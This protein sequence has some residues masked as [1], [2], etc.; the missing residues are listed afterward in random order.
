L[1][2]VKQQR[3]Y[4]TPF[5]LSSTFF[6]L[7][8]F[9]QISL[10]FFGA[11]A[12]FF[13][14]FPSCFTLLSNSNPSPWVSTSS[15]QIVARLFVSVLQPLTPTWW[16][17]PAPPPSGC[18]RVKHTPHPHSL[19]IPLQPLRTDVRQAAPYT[20]FSPLNSTQLRRVLHC[21]PPLLESLFFA[22]LL[23]GPPTTSQTDDS[24]PPPPPPLAPHRPLH[25][26]YH[27]VTS[28]P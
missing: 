22:A 5:L 4:L 19:F 8:L 12:K 13:P 9:R 25:D 3:L 7:P 24:T 16:T 14:K 28:V 27:T 15:R 26:Y 18:F 21:L 11:C 17:A 20:Q 6:S 10:S 1:C 23:D 2:R